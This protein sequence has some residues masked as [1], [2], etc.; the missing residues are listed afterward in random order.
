MTSRLDEDEHNP[1]PLIS[2]DPQ[3]GTFRFITKLYTI[4]MPKDTVTIRA[5]FETLAV[6]MYF[7][8]MKY[9]AKSVLRTLDLKTFTDYV[10]WL[11]GPEV[12][13]QGAVD[14]HDK[15]IAS[16]TM[17]QVLNYDFRIREEVAKLVN[18]GKEFKAALEI[19][20]GDEKL[21]RL[22]SE[23]PV[24]VTINTSECRACSAPNVKGGS[25]SGANSY[26]A[27][28]GVETVSKAALNRIKQ[29]AK[30]EAEKAAKRKFAPL[31][32][33]N[34]GGAGQ[35]ETR[36]Q[37]RAKKRQQAYQFA[38]QNGGI[39][40]GSDGGF[41]RL[42]NQQQQAQGGGL[43]KGA[44]KGGQDIRHNGKPICYNWNRGVACR[45]PQCDMAHVCL[46][47]KGP[48]RKK[49]CPGSAVG[50]SSLANGLEEDEPP[51]P[52]GGSST[53]GEFP[54]LIHESDPRC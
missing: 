28:P 7:M 8:H 24:T 37:K 13:G 43:G 17:N 3:S 34:G 32:L 20:E 51:P 48:H 5:R 40:D 16:P 49:D 36:A 42:L 12:G 4:P 15:V 10:R 27:S 2:V 33:Q 35:G 50:A 18:E 21:R 47:C 14:D 29:Q 45:N 25:S 30:A 41:P 46:L 11:F 52:L 1:P 44:G 38:L 31:A 22:H 6:C 39:G 23:R 19:A 26:R 53:N 54:N 9:P